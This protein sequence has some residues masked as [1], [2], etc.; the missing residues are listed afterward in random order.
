MIS[1]Y[2]ILFIY[3]FFLIS[4]PLAF[5]IIDQNTKTLNLNSTY[6]SGQVNIMED[7]QTGMFNFF[8]VD[9]SIFSETLAISKTKFIDRDIEKHMSMTGIEY[10]LNSFY[11]KLYK[12]VASKGFFTE[13][14]D[15]KKFT[16]SNSVDQYSLQ[17]TN[18]FLEKEFRK[19]NSQIVFEIQKSLDDLILTRTKFVDQSLIMLKDNKNKLKNKL[20]IDIETSVLKL[21]AIQKKILLNNQNDDP[22]YEIQNQL[23]SNLISNLYVTKLFVT[24]EIIID[25]GPPRIKI[26]RKYNSSENMLILTE[27]QTYQNLDLFPKTVGEDLSAFS[28]IVYQIEEL[29]FARHRLQK[30]YIDLDQNFQF[31]EYSIPKVSEKSLFGTLNVTYIIL[32][33]LFLGFIIASSIILLINFRDE[34]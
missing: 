24:D 9:D 29:G 7:L 4:L 2:K 23:I 20:L 32:S 26:M 21:E 25:R 1:R 28:S 17:E 31:I 34:N 27:N 3:L 33:G 14:W 10:I 11:S 5:L 15:D 13:I 30:T 16:I 18:I 22:N 19:I 8:Y 12:S 6:T